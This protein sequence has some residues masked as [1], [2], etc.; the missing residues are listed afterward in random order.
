[1]DH[2]KRLPRKLKKE[3]KKKHFHRY[4]N[5]WLSCYNIIVEYK[6]FYKNA[7]YWNMNESLRFKD[8][9]GNRSIFKK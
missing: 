4:G 8:K 6:W 5:P 2:Y 1:M 9:N 7:F 3:L